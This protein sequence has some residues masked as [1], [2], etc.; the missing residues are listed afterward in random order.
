MRSEADV[1]EV[2]RL[3]AAGLS[4]SAIAAATDVSP[5]TIKRWLRRDEKAVVGS[6]G[7]SAHSDCAER[8]NLVSDA[9]PAPYAFLLGMYLGDGHIV[10][11][12]RGVYRLEIACCEWYPGI[13][14]ECTEAVAHVLPSCRVGHRRRPGVVLVGCYSKH[15]PCL[16][17]QHGPGP[18]HRRRI[19]LEPWQEHIAL[20][21]H[22][23]LFVRGLLH[24]DGW[25]GTNRVR[26]MN[27]SSY[28]YP[29]YQFC[30][31][32][33]DIREL[34][35]RACDRLG[36]HTRRMNAFNISVARRDSVAVLDRFVGPK[37]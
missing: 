22:P 9:P 31:H 8:C 20:G 14:E 1:H 23:D 24:S 35:V 10:H 13:V 21:E 33:T 12:H 7:R 26:A 11:N 30:N 6:R 3:R 29:R 32:S 15:L 5:S 4:T 17:P 25:R 28:E 19:A 36:V 16:F 18:K 34:F 37:S 2:F 27:G